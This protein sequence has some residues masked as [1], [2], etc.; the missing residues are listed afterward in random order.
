MPP[1]LETCGALLHVAPQKKLGN[2]FASGHT[3]YLWHGPSGNPTG[4][5]VIARFKF[6]SSPTLLKR[7]L[8]RTLAGVLFFRHRQ[9]LANAD[10]DAA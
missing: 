3:N 6:S 2:Y 1:K 4:G 8:S 7:V 5:G 10:Q 9:A